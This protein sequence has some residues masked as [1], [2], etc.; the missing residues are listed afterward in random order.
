MVQMTAQQEIHVLCEQR[1]TRVTIA[2]IRE[3]MMHEGEAK[4]WEGSTAFG[5]EPRDL[6]LGQQQVVAVAFAAEPCGIQADDVNV[7]RMI[8][9]TDGRP[10]T[11]A[12]MG[13]LL[14]HE[15]GVAE[16]RHPPPIRALACEQLIELC[17]RISRRRF[18]ARDPLRAL[19][20]GHLEEE[21]SKLL[22]AR[23][24]HVSV[25][26]VVAG[27]HE[28]SVR[29]E[30]KTSDHLLDELAGLRVLRFETR[31]RDVAREANEVHRNAVRDEIVEVLR[32]RISEH[33]T[34]APVPC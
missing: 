26:V 34:P 24:V 11:E 6:V 7:E 8:G 29:G 20:V 32:P 12:A 33:T 16:R 17:V 10:V 9:K 19:F 23:L 4:T 3:R 2:Q 14:R 25:H 18:P 5:R 22:P 30:A 28:E 21:R 27:N 13:R 31:L 1:T 15:A